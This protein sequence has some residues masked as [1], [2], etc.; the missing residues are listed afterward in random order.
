MPA[1]DPFSTQAGQRRKTDPSPRL[2][3]IANE[4]DTTIVH[5]PMAASDVDICASSEASAAIEGWAKTLAQRP[6]KRG[7][8][9]KAAPDDAN[10]SAEVRSMQSCPIAVLRRNSVVPACCAPKVSR[11]GARTFGKS[12]PP[13]DAPRIAIVT[14]RII[15]GTDIEPTCDHQLSP[16]PTRVRFV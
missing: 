7:N 6:A 2:T 5:T 8:N 16:P 4:S 10:G 13:N 11:A 1:S 15:T 9:S 12:R 14:E 3:E